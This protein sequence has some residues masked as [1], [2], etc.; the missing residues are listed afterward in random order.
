M[1][2]IPILMLHTVNDRPMD[3]PMGT[4]SVSAKGLEAYLKVFKRWK[5]QMISMDDFLNENYDRDQNYIVLTF[6][7]GYKD[8]YTV[9][10][11]IMQKYGARGTI[12]VN[13]AYTSE[14]SNDSDW[15]FMTWEEIQAAENSGV[16]DI[17]AHT[18]THEFIFTSDRV[19]DYYTPDKFNKYYWLAWM[20]H[21]DAPRKWNSTANDY[22][23]K[24]PAG[25]P[26]FEYGRRISCRKF[27]PNQEYVDFLIRNYKTGETDAEF[28]GNR[29]TYESEEEY[30]E[31]VRWE[32]EECKNQLEK[33]VNKTIHS[34][35]FPG[36]GY[37]DYAL[38]IAEKC[39]Y[40]CYMTASRARIGNNHDHLAQ[41]QQGMFV[42]LNRTSFSLIHPGLF[43]DAF[44]DYWVAKL[45]LGTYQNI[46][47]YQM[48]KKVLS[49][50]LHA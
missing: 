43:P 29:G 7:D 44:W 47:I 30:R 15:G 46:W 10:K 6:D 50:V 13:P 22:R 25:Y 17:Q 14:K 3:N 49:K 40:R 32:I 37:T 20:L 36:G 42:G 45:S 12:F 19:V 48:L 11:P 1:H 28:D 16:F 8:N 4:L 27:L 21:P 41:I 5:Y 26:V 23:D 2:D 24:I 34:L 39:G 9:A 31:Y 38:D 18:M 33:K 35:C